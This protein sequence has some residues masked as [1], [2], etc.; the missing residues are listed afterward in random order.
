VDATVVAS[1]EQ[2]D[3]G[4]YQYYS[5]FNLTVEDINIYPDVGFS[6]I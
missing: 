4:E 5:G 6:N 1:T 3:L 2:S